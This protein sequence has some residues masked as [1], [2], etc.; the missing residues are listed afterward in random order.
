VIGTDAL[1]RFVEATDRQ[2]W[3]TTPELAVELVNSG[4]WTEL[5]APDPTQ[6]NV[7][8]FSDPGRYTVAVDGMDC[9]DCVDAMLGSLCALQTV[10]RSAPPLFA[11]VPLESPQTSHYI[12]KRFMMLTREELGWLGS[13]TKATSPILQQHST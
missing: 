5:G 7:Q 13:T 9:T 4:L 11:R 6:H 12:Y 8:P 3:W 1:T 10:E 2:R